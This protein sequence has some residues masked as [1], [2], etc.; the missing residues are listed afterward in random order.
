MC[1]CWASW[2]NKGNIVSLDADSVFSLQKL[3]PRKSSYK[4]ENVFIYKDVKC[5]FT[6]YAGKVRNNLVT[7]NKRMV[8]ESSY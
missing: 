8:R 4:G 5:Y 2:E 7:N 3:I 6:Y 1:N